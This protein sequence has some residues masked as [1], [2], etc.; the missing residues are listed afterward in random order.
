MDG[1]FDDDRAYVYTYGTKTGREIDTNQEK[2]LIALRVAPSVDN[3]VP[4]SFG[5]RELVNRM[6]LVLRSAEVSA[7][8]PFYIEILLNP[9]LST[10]IDWFDVGGTSLAQYADLTKQGSG[11]LSVELVGGEVIFGFYVGNGV[12]TVSLASVKEISNSILGGGLDVLTDVAPPNPTGV[13]Q[14]VLRLSL[15]ERR[16]LQVVRVLTNV[17]LTLESPGQRHRHK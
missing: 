12:N 11:D 15:F 17:L 3:G 7:N 5:S 2:A 14:T 8:G 13:F 9:I 6:Q 4:G 10:A 16:T 1:R